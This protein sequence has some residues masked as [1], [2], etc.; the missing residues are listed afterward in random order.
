MTIKDIARQ[1]GVSAITVSRAVNGR[2]DISER[3]RKR[4][5]K[6]VRCSGWRPSMHARGL[7]RGRSYTLGFLTN[8]ISTSFTPQILETIE[9]VAMEHR[10]WVMV[11][12]TQGRAD[13]ARRAFDDLIAR[14][15]DGLIVGPVPLPAEK[16]R[17]AARKGVRIV[18]TY[19]SQGDETP[20]FA[21]SYETV[22]RLA[23][24]H[25]A[26][27]G[28]RRSL[29]LHFAPT[30]E[31]DVF[32]YDRWRG[33]RAGGGEGFVAEELSLE[34]VGEAGVK[35]RLAKGDLT[36]VFCQ[37]DHALPTVYR[38]AWELGLSIPRN[39]SVIG[40]VD[41]EIAEMLSPKATTV[42]VAKREVARAAAL[43]I[44][45]TPPKDPLR[46]RIF[47][48]ALVIRDSTAKARS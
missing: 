43:A 16:I 21:V 19:L 12:I 48:P 11:A 44:I 24:E 3:T 33:F 42:E 8:R 39:L 1:A 31:G 15:V 29:Y 45:E 23:G 28:H 37:N 4:I 34:A 6:I 5:L 38:A 32:A 18:A 17:A 35:A 36:A 14:G 10:W 27:L 26:G 41:L 22:G 40:S 30:I 13:Y 47:P 46:G 7:V 25:L 9:E 2:P 20:L